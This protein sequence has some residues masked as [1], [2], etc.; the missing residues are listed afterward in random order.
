MLTHLYI[1]NYALIEELD[2][3]L[4]KGFSVITGETGAGKSILLGA[5]NM[6]IGQRADVKSIQSGASKCIVEAHFDIQKYCLESFF[7]ENDLDYDNHTCIIRRE[8][9]VN[10]KSRAFI[11]DSPTTLSVLRELGYHLV[12]IHS[13]HQ[14]LLLAEENFQLRMLDTMAQHDALILQYTNAFDAYRQTLTK[15][16][17]AKE[18]LEKSRTDEDYLRYQLDLLDELNLKEDE[19]E[20]LEQ[21]QN[22]LSHAEEIKEAL[23]KV[24][25]LLQSDADGVGVLSAL[26]QSVQII[27]SL[28]KIYPSVSSYSERI[29]SCFIELKDISSDFSDMSENIEFNPQRLS[30]IDARLDKI[31]SLEKKYGLN[32]AAELVEFTTKLRDQLNAINCGDEQIHQLEALAQQ[33]LEEATRLA[34]KL[35]AE[36]ALAAQEIQK[37]IQE[38]LKRLD[39]PNN[40]FL[41]QINCNE[42]LLSTGLD[43]ITFLFSANKNIP[44]RPISE[45]ASGGEIARVMLA[46][47]AITSDKTNLPTIIFDEIDTGVSGKV[48]DSMAL[49]MQQMSRGENHQVIAI[50]HLPQIASLGTSHYFVYKDDASGQTTSHIRQLTDEERITE[51]AHMLSGSTITDAAIENAKQLLQR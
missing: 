4:H 44:L 45:V 41:I 13:Q 31:Y 33:Q 30:E 16:R 36:R 32:S 20:Q 28:S 39:M 40:Q 11:N 5:I 21:E 15:L 1:K 26:K 43:N 19:E 24:D 12:D 9:M 50:T 34:K 18:D 23:F 25:N 38:I 48:A 49:M 27:Q 7:D 3:D 17:Q 6:L 42:N 10:G 47:K 35:S 8:V 29:E 2:V 46:L 14:N 22:E 51:V 37:Q